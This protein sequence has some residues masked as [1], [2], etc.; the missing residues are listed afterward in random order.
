MERNTV[1]IK[2]LKEL[3]CNDCNLTSFVPQLV[4]EDMLGMEQL[5]LLK[6]RYRVMRENFNCSCKEWQGHFGE[7]MKPFNG[8]TDTT[9][10]PVPI[11]HPEFKADFE[12]I[13]KGAIGVD[14]PTWFNMGS[15]QRIMLIAQDPLRSKK[16]YGKCHD[17]VLSSPFGLHDAGH[18]ARGNGGRMMYTLVQKLVAGG[19]GV[20]LT[21][22]RKFFVYDHATSDKHAESRMHLYAAILKK[23]VEAVK[24][25]LCVCLG[26]KAKETFSCMG[27]GVQFIGLPHLT[28]TSRWAIIQKFQDLKSS[29]ATNENVAERYA[30]E[31]IQSIGK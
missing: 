18:R 1:D 14:L 2:D 3:F 11:T 13:G 12:K 15:N 17:A 29:G 21:D 8:Y 4:A 7:G 9:A 25:S 27:L 22:T 5:P 26:K 31:I 28:G 10:V 30:Q 6:T 24:P 23:E 19:Y 20:Y 16:W